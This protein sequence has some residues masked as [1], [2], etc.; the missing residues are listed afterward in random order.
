MAVGPRRGQKGS[1][2]GQAFSES[3]GVPQK[4]FEASEQARKASHHRPANHPSPTRR[5]R[6]ALHFQ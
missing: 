2:R 3:G 6:S 5:P 1:E 4:L